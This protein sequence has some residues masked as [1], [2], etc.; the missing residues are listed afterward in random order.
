MVAD[1]A[2]ILIGLALVLIVFR[3]RRPEPYLVTAL[4]AVFPDIDIIVFHP[5][6]EL[7]YVEGVLWTHRGLTHSLPIAVVV[8]ALLSYFG[9]W[10]AA[11]IGYGSHI[12]FDYLTGGVRLFAPFDH[13]LYGLSFDWLLMNL[14]VSVFTV[15]VI[16]GGLLGMKEECEYQLPSPVAQ[17]VLERFQ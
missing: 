11:A 17:A 2:H 15:A 8:V 4:A 13:T 5:L 3:S 16:L 14:F 9:P 6:V 1:G 12:L 10:R 7:G